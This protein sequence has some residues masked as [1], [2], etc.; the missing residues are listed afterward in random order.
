M[1]KQYKVGDK[2]R[3]V[4]DLYSHLV[5]RVGVIVEDDGTSNAPY[6]VKVD[7]GSLYWKFGNTLELVAEK[8]S[9]SARIT[10]LESKVA[11]LEAEVQVLTGAKV[12]HKMSAM[13]R[14]FETLAK[15]KPTPN[16]QRK[17]VIERA[18]KFVAECVVNAKS[19]IVI[20]GEGNAQY[21]QHSNVMT[22]HVNAKKRTVVALG[23]ALYGGKLRLKAIAK[24]A[25]D[26]VFNADIGKAIA[27]GRALGLDVSEFENALKP[28]E[29][30]VG[31]TVE[32]VTNAGNRI[33]YRNVTKVT[34]DKVHGFDERKGYVCFIH[35]DAG[36]RYGYPCVNPYITDDTEAKY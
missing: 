34:A 3:I 10:E 25:P 6:R 22:F 23:H 9:K 21:R 16:Q 14:G 35:K 7:N 31:Q 13:S 15:F 1:A 27:L 18:K 17:A 2:V 33:V 20:H 5:G 26:D 12:P 30:I 19:V 4:R 8:P 28:T 11:A 24:C 36:E 29:F 32:S